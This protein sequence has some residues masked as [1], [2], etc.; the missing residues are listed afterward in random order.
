M[1]KAKVE[2]KQVA[3]SM[4]QAAKLGFKVYKRD[5]GEHCIIVGCGKK[6]HKERS[7]YC[8]DDAKAVRA[9]SNM[10]CY[11]KRQKAARKAER[12]AAGKGRAKGVPLKKDAG[13]QARLA[14]IGKAELAAQGL[15]VEAA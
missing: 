2:S 6:R 14:A 15:D 9:A 13:Q 3:R 5:D 1:T 11:R 12:I 4:K 7:P 8:A 10:A